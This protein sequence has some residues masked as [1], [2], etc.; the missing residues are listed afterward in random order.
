VP[1]S[2]RRKG[3]KI[4]EKVKGVKGRELEMDAAKASK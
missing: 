4:Y 2:L 3:F 1:K